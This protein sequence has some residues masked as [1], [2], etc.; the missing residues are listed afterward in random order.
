MKLGEQFQKE[1]ATVAPDTSIRMT[2]HMM[3]ERGVGAIVLVDGKGKPTGIVTDRDIAMALAADERDADTPVSAIVPGELVTIAENEGIFNATQYMFGYQ[4]RRLPIVD[5]AGK[6][7]GIVT[8]DDLVALLARELAN[9]A[10]AIRP[11]LA[12]AE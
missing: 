2:A 10:E 8:M 5:S 1:V 7:V 9:V 12:A 4:V 6:L 3:R 11:V